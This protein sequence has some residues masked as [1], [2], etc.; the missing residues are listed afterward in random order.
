MNEILTQ[1]LKNLYINQNFI[2]LVAAYLG[3]WFTQ[4]EN[5]MVLYISSLVLFIIIGLSVVICLIAYTCEYWCKKMYKA[6]EYKLEYKHRL[7]KSE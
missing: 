2:W 1:L 6:K 5:Y 3:V 4:K 7:K